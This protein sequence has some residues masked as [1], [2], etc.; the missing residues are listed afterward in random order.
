MCD[1]LRNSTQEQRGNSVSARAGDAGGAGGAAGQ[2]SAL[3]GVIVSAGGAKA[4]LLIYVSR[5]K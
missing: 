4:A 5:D 2:T 1:V 3:P